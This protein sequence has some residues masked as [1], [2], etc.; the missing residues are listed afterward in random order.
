MTRDSLPPGLPRPLRLYIAAVAVAGA[1]WMARLWVDVDWDAEI[2]LRT[3]FFVVLV[4][5]SGSFPLPVAPK[6]KADVTTAA[7]FGAALL[8]PAGAAAAGGAVAVVAYTFLI[9][10][11]GD[12]LRLPWYKYPFNG[13]ATG[14]YVGVT[15]FLFHHLSADGGLLTPA[16]V[17]A[18]ALM[19]MAN[20]A[21]V[22]GA[23]FLQIGISP[24]RFW[25]MGTKENGPAELSL[26]AFGFLG[27]LAYHGSAWTVLALFI[28]VAVIYMAFS[29]LARTNAQLV[30]ASAKLEEMQGRLVS[31]SKL[32]SIG[33]MSLDMA[34]QVK[35][36]LAIL[37]GRLEML[38]DRIG[39]GSA[40]N[41]DLEIAM[42]AGWRLQ[43]LVQSFTDV[44]RRK[45]VEVDLSALLSEAF[46]IA[47]LRVD[48]KADSTWDCQEGLP[49]VMGNP[50]LIR[51]ALSNI[52]CNALEATKEGSLIS[53]SAHSMGG[54]VVV[55]IRDDGVGIS[56][57]AKAHL[58]EPFQSTKANG[59]GLGMFASRH[60]LELHRGSLT[61][62]SERGRGTTV[63]ITLPAMVPA[64]RSRAGY[65]D[66]RPPVPSK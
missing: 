54:H 13:A 2:A 57:A 3:G 38:K 10:Y 53:T 34:H 47:G 20:T 51:E 22:T 52:Y 35:N 4:I 58:F 14:I 55:R 39:P 48:I 64:Q 60:I 63:T 30:E 41:R 25:W 45:F 66:S 7:L 11:W 59:T 50:V 6:V 40:P 12:R 29:R 23:A 32:A 42:D 56:E 61:V 31:N 33:A 9:R 5:V 18:A 28:P 26:L 24:L 1:A 27:A 19:Y 15:A 43:E 17:P 8:L 36:P 62:E 49:R 65:I 21:L 46:G 16:I 44:G 37:L